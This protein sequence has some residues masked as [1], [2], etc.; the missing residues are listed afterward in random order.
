MGEPAPSVRYLIPPPHILLPNFL[1]WAKRWLDSGIDATAGIMLFTL[2]TTR[3]I[4]ATF[5]AII[6]WY[7]SGECSWGRCRVCDVM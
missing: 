5:P 3:I 2:E 1:A 7:Y 4:E 6:K